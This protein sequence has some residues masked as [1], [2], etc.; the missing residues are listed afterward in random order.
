MKR[1]PAPIQR[2]HVTPFGAGINKPRCPNCGSTALLPLSPTAEDP[3]G[4]YCAHCPWDSRSKAAARAL[5]R[6]I[7]SHRPAPIP[8]APPLQ[9]RQ[10]DRPR[11][12]NTQQTAT[13]KPKPDVARLVRLQVTAFAVA[14]L[15]SLVGLGTW[16]CSLF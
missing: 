1:A 11:F 5:P 6:A 15:V 7:G 2:A 10:A 8:A 4:S 9:R 14:T 12:A 3:N 13:Q 16:I